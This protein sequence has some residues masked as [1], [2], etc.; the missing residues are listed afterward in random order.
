MHDS[1]LVLIVDDDALVRRTIAHM[2]RNSGIINEAVGSAAEAKERVA[3][4]MDK[5]KEPARIALA[6]VDLRLKESESGAELIAS[7]KGM[8]DQLEILIVTGY[9]S[10][11][12]HYP[13]IDVVLKPFSKNEPSRDLILK[14]KRALERRCSRMQTQEM[15]ALIQDMHGMLTSHIEDCMTAHRRTLGDLIKQEGSNPIVWLLL[16]TLISVISWV[17]GTYWKGPSK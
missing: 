4:G 13:D 10:D 8:D 9:P 16:T 5:D 11:S 7:I 3:A 1:D 6:L 17:A 15:H 14:V 12:A 2:L